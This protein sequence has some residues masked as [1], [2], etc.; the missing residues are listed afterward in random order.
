MWTSYTGSSAEEPPTTEQFEQWHRRMSPPENE[1]PAGVGVTVLLGRTDNVGVG[2]TQVEAFSTGFRF[3]LAV[4][5]RQL[6]PQLARGGLFMLIGSH[7]HPG[8]EVLL[9]D[10]LLLGIEYPDGRRASTLNDMRSQGPGTVMDTEQLLLVQHGGGGGELTVDQTYWVTPLPPEGPVTVVLTW[11]SFGIAES[12]TNLDGTL[13]REA[14]SQSQ[15]LW[16]PQSAEEPPDPPP[17]PRP[18][19]GWFAEP[20]N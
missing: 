5:V 6:R 8:I 4:R 2:I 1:F 15:T 20:P 17:T 19:T 18:S 16:P 11:Q 13:I 9:E 12:R 7:M 10:R 3:T 14:A